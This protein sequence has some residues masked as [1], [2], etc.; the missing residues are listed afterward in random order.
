MIIISKFSNIDTFSLK[1]NKIGHN[2]KL[3]RL[4]ISDNLS[5]IIIILSPGRNSNLFVL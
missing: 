5:Q 4:I 3:N 1:A 2:H